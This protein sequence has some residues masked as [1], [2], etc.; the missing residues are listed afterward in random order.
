MANPP[1]SDRIMNETLAA[2][3]QYGGIRAA[4]RALG[5]SYSTLFCRHKTAKDKLGGYMAKQRK[6]NEYKEIKQEQPLDVVQRIKYEKKIEHLTQKLKDT[7]SRL[8][9]TITHEEL[10][11]QIFK[12]AQ[13][14][15]KVPEWKEKPRT[16]SGYSG[17]PVAILSDLHYGE[18]VSLNQMG[19]TNQYN[20]DIAEKRLEDWTN[21]LIDLCFKHETWKGKYPGLVLCLGGD[22]IS[23]DIHN[24][25]KETNSLPT[26]ATTLRLA[27]VLKASILKLAD[28]FGV[29]MVPCVTGN[30]GRMTHKPQAKDYNELNY[31]TLL[32]L[33]LESSLKNDKRIN[34]I[35]P[36][37]TLVHFSIYGFNYALT[38]GNLLG[39]KGGDGIIGP[40][41]PITRGVHKLV[42]SESSKPN[43]NHVD[44]VIMGHW[45]TAMRTRN[46]FVNG[47]LKGYDEYA[48]TFLRTS[49]ERPA[50]IMWFT[51]PEHGAIKFQAVFS[52]ADMAKYRKPKQKHEWFDSPSCQNGHWK[53]T[54]YGG[55]A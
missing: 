49:F 7:E 52:D 5:I 55:P 18:V 48:R 24:E 34:F 35:F 45:H 43:S 51:H 31:E 21:S 19:G 1:L 28:A 14:P 39:V 27:G 6:P 22:M 23:G 15:I 25:L 50:Q 17:V 38:H 46:I 20:I 3:K 32:Y 13:S 42:A 2:V 36:N 33:T 8:A 53:H 9:A 47:S 37:D 26:L 11:E 54:Q 41:G 30:H 40:I 4:S 16:G 10:R 44:Y 12:L 29:V